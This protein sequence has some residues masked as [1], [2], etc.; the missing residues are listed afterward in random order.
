MSPS[1]NLNSSFWIWWGITFEGNIG[2]KLVDMNLF[3]WK[4][5]LRSVKI[6]NIIFQGLKY[7]PRFFKGILFSIIKFTKKNHK[8]N[9]S[10]KMTKINYFEYILWNTSWKWVFFSI[11]KL[12][13]LPPAFSNFYMGISLEQ[14]VFKVWLLE[15]DCLFFHVLS[16][17]IKFSDFWEF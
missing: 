12:L 15:E 4:T 2:I 1:D 7:P 8:C 5:R 6:I 17:Y 13:Y 9:N 11:K 14:C 3:P 10:Y 16:E